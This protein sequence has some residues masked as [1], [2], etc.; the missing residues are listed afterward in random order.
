MAVYCEN[1]TEHINT[2]CVQNERNCNAKDVG[3]STYSYRRILNGS[4]SIRNGVTN[5]EFVYATRF[6]SL[7]H[8]SYTLARW[9]TGSTRVSL[10]SSETHTYITQVN[11][12]FFSD[13]MH[14]ERCSE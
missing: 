11:I 5:T 3:T 12:F 10:Q 6:V 4:L 1:H 7:Q 13:N 8:T 9:V 14:N 2:L